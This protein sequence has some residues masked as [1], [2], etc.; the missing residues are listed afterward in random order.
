MSLLSH[1]RYARYV[2]RH[3][4]FVLLACVQEAPSLGLRVGLELVWRGLWHDLSKLSPTEWFPYV[5]RFYGSKPSPRDATGAYD[6]LKVGGD[7]DLAWL[8]HQHHN[9]HHHQYW[10]LR[11]DS[12]GTKV[13]EMPPAARAE[14]LCD[15]RGAGLAQGKS[16]VLGWYAANRDKMRLHP[17]TRAWIETRLGLKVHT[18]HWV[19]CEQ[20]KD[21]T[22][23]C[24]C[25]EVEKRHHEPEEQ[26]DDSD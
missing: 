4:A 13:L 24:N 11:G 6:P 25:I 15:W 10:V 8:S 22:R 26:D 1:L 18:G 7:F 12:D 2:A 9:D 21:E 17:S 16:D 23:A 20:E 14:M 5:E 19:G 3:K